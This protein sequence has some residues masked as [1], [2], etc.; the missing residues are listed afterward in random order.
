MYAAHSFL[1]C[2]GRASVGVIRLP[3]T[4]NTPEPA[5]SHSAMLTLENWLLRPNCS[6]NSPWMGKSALEERAHTHTPHAHFCTS[7]LVHTSSCPHF[8]TLTLAPFTHYSVMYIHIYRQTDTHAC[9]YTHMW[10]LCMHSTLCI[11]HCLNTP[12]MSCYVNTVVCSPPQVHPVMNTPLPFCSNEGQVSIT[13]Y[14]LKPGPCKSNIQG[15]TGMKL[16]SCG[17]RLGQSCF[18]WRRKETQARC[19]EKKIIPQREWHY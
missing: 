14:W 10:T 9:M 13:F 5:V 12:C 18:L 4:G 16:P 19:F 15:A 3:Q 11:S 2:F 8:S 1:Q 17:R 6:R 7:C